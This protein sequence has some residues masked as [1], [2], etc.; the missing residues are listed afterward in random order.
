MVYFPQFHKVIDYWF[1]ILAQI[2]T[3]EDL[4]VLEIGMVFLDF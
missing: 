1:T 3:D 2:E 4:Q